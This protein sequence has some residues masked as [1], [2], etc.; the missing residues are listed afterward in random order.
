MADFDLEREVRTAY[1]EVYAILEE[2][3]R[4]GRI[5]IHF[6][7]NVVH[8]SLVVEES[9]TQESIQEL[10]GTIDE[11]L[12]DAAGIPREELIIHVFQGRMSGVFSDN[13]FGSNDNGS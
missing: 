7:Y 10:I 9:L 4:V 1:S 12:A 3:R 8:V 5:D 11:D 13:E 2:D 6:T